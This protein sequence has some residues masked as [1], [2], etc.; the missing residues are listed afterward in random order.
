MRRPDP[1]PPLKQRL[2]TLL[3]ERL[4]GWSGEWAGHL[5][6]ADQPRMSDLRN[7]RLTVFSLDRLVRFVERVGG[8]V[9][10]DVAWTRERYI[11]RAK[12]WSPWGRD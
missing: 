10:I 8:D 6:G 1:I 3:V 7:N 4:E 9:T 12:D 5:I 11:A 2:A